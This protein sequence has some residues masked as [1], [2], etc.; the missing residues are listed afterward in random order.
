M[1][2][3]KE[4]IEIGRLSSSGANKQP[5]KYIVSCA[6]ETNAKIFETLSWAGALKDWP[7]PEE[8]E[9][10]AAY[11]VILA[12]SAIGK[13]GVD[14]GIAATNILLGAVD[15]GL[16]GCILGTVKQDPLRKGLDIGERF[17]IA[18]VLAI[19]KPKEIVQIETVDETG[20][21]AYWR[22]EQQVHHVPKRKLEDCI[23]K[24]FA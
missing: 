4:L 1:E 16:G 2:T 7:G 20:A 24:E 8:G 13:S 11:I 18:L 10:P 14:H 19:G 6:P 22:D 15:K 23:V 9:R 21:T 3:L 17:E 5:L 12:D